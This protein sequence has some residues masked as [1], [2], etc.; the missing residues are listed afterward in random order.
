MT[1]STRTSIL[2]AI[3]GVIEQV[4]SVNT[5]VCSNGNVMIET[6][7]ASDLPLVQIVFNRETPLYETSHHAMWEI[8]FELTCYVLGG[9]EDTVE[10]IIKDIKDAIGANQTMNQTCVITEIVSVNIIGDFPL[11]KLI[12]DMRSKYEKGVAD[13]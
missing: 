9:I 4:S 8:S 10:N 5:V 3:S 1:D 6:Y 7:K 12:F 11:W 13:A 2:S